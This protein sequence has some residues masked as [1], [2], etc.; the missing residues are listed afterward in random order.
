MKLNYND[1]SLQE[2]EIADRLPKEK[3]FKIFGRPAHC[4]YEG[5]LDKV[6]GCPFIYKSG[7]LEK[8]CVG[9][10]CRISEIKPLI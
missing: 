10:H 8:H 2:K 6:F 4:G 7:D 5:A 9:C 1:L 3:F